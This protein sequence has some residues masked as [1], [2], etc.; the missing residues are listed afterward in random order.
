MTD[1]TARKAFGVLLGSTALAAAAL[2]AVPATASAATPAETT[3][4]STQQLLAAVTQQP[5]PAAIDAEVARLTKE[6]SAT[7]LSTYAPAPTREQRSATAQRR[8]AAAQSGD[9]A[10]V[11]GTPK[12]V[13]AAY[14]RRFGGSPVVGAVQLRRDDCSRYWGE[15]TMYEKMPKNAFATA[16]I[17][18]LK[19][20]S[21]VT[22]SCDSGGGNGRVTE[23]QTTC[24]TPKIAASDTEIRL[25]ASAHEYHGG[26]GGWARVSWGQTPATR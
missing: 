9:A 24:H 14:L 20:G 4:A 5:S 19:D 23:N 10:A 3:L 18:K 21:T 8:L 11:C 2:I 1:T 7:V 17:T 22:W 6:V 15:L 16:F 26:N 12:I 25:I 13:S